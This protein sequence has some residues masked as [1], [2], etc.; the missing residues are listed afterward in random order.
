MRHSRSRT[1]KYAATPLA[2]RRGVATFWIIG[3]TPAFLGLIVL[4]TDYGNLWLAHEDLQNAVDAAAL[5]GAKQWGDLSDVGGLGIVN[6]SLAH[7]AAEEY[8]EANTV[9][10]QTIDIDDN[11]NVAAVNNN[12]NC[13]GDVLLGTATPIFGT[14]YYDFNSF[15]GPNPIPATSRS[16]RVSATVTVNSLWETFGVGPYTVRATATALYSGGGAA[17]LISTQ[18]DTGPCS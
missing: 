3:L 9:L 17:Q 11:D 14:P 5:A 2:N 7:N 8:A 1:S 6:R 16:C 13:P 12:N 4:V 18:T 15:G 10:G